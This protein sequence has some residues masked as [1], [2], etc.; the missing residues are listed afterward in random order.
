MINT[1]G[2]GWAYSKCMIRE[3]SKL[4]ASKCC[5]QCFEDKLKIMPLGGWPG[6]LRSVMDR[7]GSHHQW[8]KGKEEKMVSVAVSV[9]AMIKNGAT[10]R[11]IYDEYPGYASSKDR[12][13]KGEICESNR[14]K[15]WGEGYIPRE[16]IVLWGPTGCG[17]TACAMRDPHFKR[18]EGYRTTVSSNGNVW[19]EGYFNQKVILIDEYRC[20]FPYS[21]LLELLDG[22]PVEVTSRYGQMPLLARTIYITTDRHPSTWYDWDRVGAYGQ[23]ER[24][25]SAI[26]HLSEKINV[27]VSGRVGN[28]ESTLPEKLKE[29]LS[30]NVWFLINLYLYW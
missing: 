27:S 8:G 12:F 23:L 1:F 28:I 14:L 18:G 29:L 11:E 26:K 5:K 4:Y 6:C 16:V 10:W 19:W 24:R 21:K 17:K 3:R 9:A 25:F 22:Y 2:K 15:L 20:C 7:V 30:Q 13:I